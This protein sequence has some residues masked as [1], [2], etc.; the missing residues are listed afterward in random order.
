MKAKDLK[1]RLIESLRTNGPHQEWRGYVGMSGI[2]GCPRDLYWRAIDPIL[3]SD[4]LHWYGWSGY[5]HEAALKNLLGA[6]REAILTFLSGSLPVGR[7]LIA[8]FD[9]R[10]RGHT[11]HEAP[12]GTLIEYKS[13]GWNKFLKIQQRGAGLRHIAQVQAYMR[14][15]NYPNAIIVYVARDVPHREWQ[16]PFWCLDVERD[17]RM[18]DEL[19]EKARMV[20]AAVDVGIPPEC[21]C[22][23]CNR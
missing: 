3:A 11:D 2:G 12:D 5:L 23:Y 18:M 21:T 1:H 10:Y 13:T 20:L 19:D 15:G 16:I 6:H 4:Q 14:H 17:E 8:D 22:N 9:P 7:E